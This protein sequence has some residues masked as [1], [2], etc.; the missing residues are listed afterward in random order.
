MIMD[1][2]DPRAML[3]EIDDLLHAV[4]GD[5]VDLN[6]EDAIRQAA[7]AWEARLE[8]EASQADLAEIG[9]ILMPA[10]DAASQ[11]ADGYARVIVAAKNDDPDPA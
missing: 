6:S 8:S 5:D 9:A 3:A 10:A 11:V 2:P 4:L 1:L 7:D